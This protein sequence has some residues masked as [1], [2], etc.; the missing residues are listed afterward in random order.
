MLFLN[1]PVKGQGHQAFPQT[2]QERITP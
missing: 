2:A 1:Q